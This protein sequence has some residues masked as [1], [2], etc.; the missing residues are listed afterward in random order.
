MLRVENL[1]KRYGKK[2]V[3]SN[4]SFDVKKGQ[5]LGF[6][7][8][9]GA[10]KSTTMNML[11]GYLAPTSGKI[12][13]E[14][15]NSRKM[16]NTYKQEIGYLPEIPP[17][18]QDLT[19]QEQLHFIC[20]LKQIQ[21]KALSAHIQEVCA[22]VGIEDKRYRLIRNLSKG[23]RQRV[24][25]AQALIGNP[26]LL[27]LDEPTVGLDPEQ[28]LSIRNLIRE[29]GK[30]HGII[31]SSHLL[32]EIEEVC[33]SAVIIQ[34]GEMKA[35]GELQQIISSHQKEHRI[36]V[37]IKVRIKGE[38]AKMALEAL[39]GVSVLTSLVKREKDAEDFMLVTQEDV[40]EILPKHLTDYGCSL[41][42][43]Y[44]MDVE[45]ESI[46]L[47]LTQENMEA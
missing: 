46:F 31:F 14:G 7:G 32:H 15:E 17:L 39:P 2:Y 41:R 21:K 11:A 19:V 6:L 42:M 44:P 37:R 4:I 33:D 47:Q 23:Y 40:R 9:N 16:G 35:F 30:D 20:G 12:M 1:S 10:G 28:I 43:L 29:L 27:I 38:K 25:I 34:E 5:V 3:V 8:R 13:F 18:Y 26:K 22:L 45:L 24:G 36:K